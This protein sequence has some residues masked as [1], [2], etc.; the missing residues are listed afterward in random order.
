MIKRAVKAATDAGADP[1]IVVLGA[2]AD[3]IRHAIDDS[4]ARIVVNENWSTGLASS[5]ATGM[6]AVD[7]ACDAIL[8]TLADQP[9]V[10]AKALGM[11]LAAFDSE[12]RVVASSYGDTIGVPAVFGI[13]FRDALS[14]LSGDT[15]A[16]Q[17]LRE[18]MTEVSI[19]QLDQAAH[20]VDTPS[21]VPRLEGTMT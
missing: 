2:E 5:L 20:D 7:A 21:D 12:H 10:D 18:R 19:V 15:G 11:L 9:L 6:N 17:W 13:E 16:G 4:Q 8:V 14:R 3:T 1:V